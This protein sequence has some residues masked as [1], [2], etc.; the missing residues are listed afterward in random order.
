MTARRRSRVAARLARPLGPPSRQQPLIRPGRA[1]SPSP[2]S[3]YRGLQSPEPRTRRNRQPLETLF[4]I[5]GPSPSQNTA[6]VNKSTTSPGALAHTAI[7]L[8]VLDRVVIY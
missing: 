1:R 8:P 7:R 4:V 3:S 5:N 2:H 6:T